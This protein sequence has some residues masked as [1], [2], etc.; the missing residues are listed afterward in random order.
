MTNQASVFISYST[1][2]EAVGRKVRNLF[3]ERGHDALLL[4][5]QQYM[6]EDFIIDLLRNEVK[7]RDWVATIDSQHAGKSI[8]VAFERVIASIY[9]KPIYHV[10][11]DCAGGSS[12]PDA[13]D[14]CLRAQVGH[15]SRRLRVF[16]SY[17][18]SDKAI[19]DRIDAALR[20]AG[21][22]TFYDQPTVSP[23]G[24]WIEQVQQA[25]DDTLERGII[26]V[27]V[28]ENSMRSRW[29]NEELSYALSRPGAYAGQIIPVL[30]PPAAPMPEPLAAIQA[31]DMRQDL[32]QAIEQL[33]STLQKLA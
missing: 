20:E 14:A 21:Y 11:A 30:I 1:L 32:D 28:S 22:E 23:G 18:S 4:K 33:L 25:I 2:D 13:E 24:K 8:W 26:L 5:L 9:H 27:L 29:V 15:I 19:A 3:E 10:D 16:L 6:T 17:S 31:L 7:A 12:V